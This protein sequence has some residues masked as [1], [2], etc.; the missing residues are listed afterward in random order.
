MVT[1]N[2]PVTRSGVPSATEEQSQ[3]TQFLLMQETTSVDPLPVNCSPLLCLGTQPLSV[4]EQYLRRGWTE[5]GGTEGEGS[6]RQR[7]R[8]RGSRPTTGHTT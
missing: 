5:S 2:L 3:V 1:R 4:Q 8:R 7:V 6:F